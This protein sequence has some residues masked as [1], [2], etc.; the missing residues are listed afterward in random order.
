MW[1]LAGITAIAVCSVG[2]L[3]SMMR[4]HR[5][6]QNRSMRDHIRRIP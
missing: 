4:R 1:L 3:R 2:L 6:Q 5:D